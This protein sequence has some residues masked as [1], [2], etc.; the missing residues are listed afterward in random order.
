M[1]A[2]VDAVVVLAGTLVMLAA[3]V[4]KGPTVRSSDID[5]DLLIV[6]AIF[7]RSLEETQSLHRFKIAVFKA[8]I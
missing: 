5:T 8:I 1:V 6:S 2:D 7:F 4:G 3:N